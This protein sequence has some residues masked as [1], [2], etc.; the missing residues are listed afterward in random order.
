MND[1]FDPITI[2]MRDKDTYL[3]DGLSDE[4]MNY[5]QMRQFLDR[6]GTTS[7]EAAFTLMLFKFQ[8]ANWVTFSAYGEL[9]SYGRGRNA[10]DS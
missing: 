2:I 3:V 1:L 4:P 7:Y 10:K 5:A 9:T 8:D 6:L